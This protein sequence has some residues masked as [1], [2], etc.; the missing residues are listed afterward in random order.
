MRKCFLL[1]TNKKEPGFSKGLLITV[2]SIKL[3]NPDVP[4]VI[5]YDYL[6]EEQKYKL[7][8]CELINVDGSIF[9]SEH[10]PDLTNAAYFRFFVDKLQYDKVFYLDNDMVL[11]DNVDEIFDINY[12]LISTMFPDRNPSME[13]TD[14]ELVKKYENIKVWKPFLMSGFICF[15]KKF[16]SDFNLLDNALRIAERYGWSFFKCCDQG[17]FNIMVQKHGFYDAGIKYNFFTHIQK[18]YSEITKINNQGFKA[19]FVNGEFIKIV[20][21]NGPEYKPWIKGNKPM[22]KEC[23]EQFLIK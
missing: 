4:I 6:T 16:W 21:W 22:Y 20:H 14:P 3:T 10:R 18:K 19:P 2:K 23:Y 17:I 11:L 1:C 5:F 9:N 12:P 13:F 7:N 15:D 8:D